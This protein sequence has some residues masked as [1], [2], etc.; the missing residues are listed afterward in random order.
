MV[1]LNNP[2]PQVWIDVPRGSVEEALGIWAEQPVFR[3]AGPRPAAFC[4][5]GL[6]ASIVIAT[7]NNFP[8]TRLCVES[9]YR[10][11]APSAFELIVVDNGS[12]DG[13]P[14]YL[15]GLAGLLPN[16][17][18]VFNSRNEGFAAANNRGILKARGDYVVLLNNDTVVTRGWVDRLIRYLEQEPAVGM[19]GPVTNSAGNE[20]M[21]AAR[22]SGL[23]ELEAFARERAR[24]YAGRFLEVEMLAMF[25]VLM[26]R[27]L[28]EEVGLLDGQFELGMFEDD[29][30]SRRVRLLGYMLICA[31]DVFVHHFG[32]R[33]WAVSPGA[34]TWRFLSA[35]AAASRKSGARSGVRRG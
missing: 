15:R 5:R 33:P 27:S 4:H 26:R 3:A 10:H 2:A 35:T 30:Y 8:Y 22:Y 28:V 29:D 1:P 17:Q 14:A 18:V 9:L 12:E 7:Y 13:T 32:G 23:E 31:E 11:T 24:A 25:C 19:A 21:V 34:R 6:R 20:Q 16:L